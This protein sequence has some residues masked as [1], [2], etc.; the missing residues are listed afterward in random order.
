MFQGSCQSLV[1]MFSR[2]SPHHFCHCS[3]SILHFGN[4][5][6]FTIKVN[7]TNW[8]LHL[9]FYFEPVV[10]DVSNQ[11]MAVTNR[12]KLPLIGQGPHGK[13]SSPRRSRIYHK[14]HSRLIDVLYNSLVG[15]LKEMEACLLL[16][17]VETAD[18]GSS[19][20]LSREAESTLLL[21]K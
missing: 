11:K 14:I 17:L 18:H 8:H 19:S 21:L 6:D 12:K 3:F 16:L 7:V 4:N 13:V 1:L 9:S 15:I 5:I 10:I 20:L 2:T